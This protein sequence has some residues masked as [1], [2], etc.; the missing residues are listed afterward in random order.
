VVA[1]QVTNQTGFVFKCLTGNAPARS[2][3]IDD[4]P[5]KQFDALLT[6]IFSVLGIDANVGHQAREFLKRVAMGETPWSLLF[7]PLSY[8]SPYVCNR[9]HRFSD[10][11]A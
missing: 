9:A 1:D 5:A 11:R 10:G 4:Q 7:P 2:T 8:P 6:D 3:D